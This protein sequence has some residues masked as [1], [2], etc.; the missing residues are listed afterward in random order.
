MAG[1]VPAIH[2]LA[3]NNKGVDARPKALKPGMTVKSA[4]QYSTHGPAH[5]GAANGA[6][7]LSAKRLPDVGGDSVGDGTGDLACSQ[8]PG[9]KPGAARPPGAEN[10]LERRRKRITY[11][12]PDAWRCLRR[13]G[14]D[15]VEGVPIGRSGV[16]DCVRFCRTS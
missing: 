16:P 10:L 6:A 7:C 5:D 14:A 2:V 13:R 3:A 11:A 4:T 9:R 8:L 15:G 1:L 12:G